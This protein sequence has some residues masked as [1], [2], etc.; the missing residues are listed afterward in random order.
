MVDCEGKTG[1]KVFTCCVEIRAIA[2]FEALGAFDRIYHA[3]KILYSPSVSTQ[4]SIQSTSRSG[5]FSSTTPRQ[6]TRT[7][8]GPPW[9]SRETCERSLGVYTSAVHA[10]RTINLLLPNPHS[11]S[12]YDIHPHPSIQ[13]LLQFSSLPE[14]LRDLFRSVS[15]HEVTLKGDLYHEALQIL[16]RFVTS[17]LYV[18]ILSE[19]REK[20]SS[21]G[22]AESLWGTAD[23]KWAMVPADSSSVSDSTPYSAGS[24]PSGGADEQ[25]SVGV[26]GEV[27][28]TPLVYEH[29]KKLA[30]QC[31]T[32]FALSLENPYNPGPLK[33]DRNAAEVETTL[34]STLCLDVLMARD[35][36]AKAIEARA[37]DAAPTLKEKI[38]D[39]TLLLEEIYRNDCERLAFSHVDLSSDGTYGDHFSK[40][41][42]AD[43]TFAPRDPKKRLHLLKELSVLA[44]GLPPGIWVRV[45]ETRNDVV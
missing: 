27:S 16:K 12:V 34:T 43:T 38:V 29:F 37:D 28:K 20:E 26:E 40:A 6:K 22:I 10:L 42:L 18:G 8:F 1:C 4:E 36:I 15:I 41:I 11:E 45:D 32:F 7:A 3:S 17:E 25:A 39:Q 30:L 33:N 21:P 2:L 31:E 9:G 19:G 24:R 13:S 23:I 5:G 35:D 14:M 44:T